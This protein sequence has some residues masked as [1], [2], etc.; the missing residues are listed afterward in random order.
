MKKL[1]AILLAVCLLTG[2]QL[3]STE[4]KESELEDKL[5]GV[6][7]TFDHLDLPFDIEGYL[8]DNVGS[9]SDGAELV[10]E[11][12]EARAYQG[13]L[14]AEVGERGWEFPGYDGIILGQ[15]WNE[16]HWVGFTT[17]GIQDIKTHVIGTETHDGIEE[18]G[19]IYVDASLEEFIY[20][21]N[22]VFMTADGE[23]YATQGDSFSSGNSGVGGMSMSINCEIK[24]T[25]GDVEN[26]Y[27]AKYTVGI[28]G[29]TLADRVVLVEMSSDHAELARTEY[30]PDAMPESVT[31]ADGAAYLIVEEYAGGTVTRRLFQPGDEHINVYY[32]GHAVYCLPSFTTINWNN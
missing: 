23:Y 27:S 31:P 6:F 14:F 17:E 22:P 9:I 3:A 18:E 12:G 19:T 2:C 15:M 21:V 28:E 11:E 29:V 1:I 20:Y 7:V 30:A 16:D 4:Q 32:Q 5:V 26:V 13:K 24:E 25:V 10:V 8:N